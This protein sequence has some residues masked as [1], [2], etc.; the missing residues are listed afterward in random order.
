M[1][2]EPNGDRWTHCNSSAFYSTFAHAN[3]IALANNEP[4]MAYDLDFRNA[5]FASAG[6]NSER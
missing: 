3:W 6:K 5:V 1:V 4:S 2:A